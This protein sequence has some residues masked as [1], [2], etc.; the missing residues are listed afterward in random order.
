MDN[1]S[2]GKAFDESFKNVKADAIVKWLEARLDEDPD[3]DRLH[4]AKIAFTMAHQLKQASGGCLE[5]DKT[6]YKKWLLKFIRDRRLRQT[7]LEKMAK[8]FDMHIRFLPAHYFETD[9]I[10]GFWRGLKPR[11]RDLPRSMP[12]ADRLKQA[13][14]DRISEKLQRRLVHESIEWCLARHERFKAEGSPLQPPAPKAPPLPPVLPGAGLPEPGEPEQLLVNQKP[15]AKGQAKA[16]G[17]A[18]AKGTANA[19]GKANAKEKAKPKADV[20]LAD[21]ELAEVELADVELAEVELSPPAGVGPLSVVGRTEFE[22]RKCAPYGDCLLEAMLV[23]LRQR[24]DSASIANARTAAADFFEAEASKSQDDAYHSRMEE[25]ATTLKSGGMGEL[26]DF[27]LYLQSRYKK[28]IYLRIKDADTSI[29]WLH[30]RGHAGKWVRVTPGSR[31][32]PQVVQEDEVIRE[33]SRDEAFLFE[34]SQ[35]K[36]GGFEEEAARERRKAEKEM[37]R[38]DELDEEAQQ[39]LAAKIDNL[40]ALA[41]QQ[42]GHYDALLPARS[43][44]EKRGEGKDDGAV[45]PAE[46]PAAPAEPKAVRVVERDVR[47]LEQG[48][49]RLFDNKFDNNEELETFVAAM[50]AEEAKATATA[51]KAMAPPRPPPRP[52]GPGGAML[53]AIGD[54]D[55][56]D[57]LSDAS[58]SSNDSAD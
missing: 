16:K 13:Y 49:R 47:I 52:A 57:D 46:H 12:W 34:A 23:N 24:A 7:R 8:T 10:E 6:D 27:S 1:A 40:K 50:E 28:A 3:D 32:L 2:I 29:A 54:P 41:G 55:L 56:A 42:A 25:A 58:D 44:V 19:K 11:F 22:L 5:M 15:K 53:V 21:V 26:V 35:I 37:E 36:A 45:R 43:G 48:G 51:P 17:K 18:K 33:V 39:L 38:F 20:E 31:G 9:P 4:E 30:E 14:D